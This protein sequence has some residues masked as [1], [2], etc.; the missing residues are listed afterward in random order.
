[1]KKL[2]PKFTF[3]SEWF[4][5][6][7]LIAVIIIAIWAYPQLPDIVPSHWNAAGEVDNYSS[8]LQHVLLFPGIMLGMYLLFLA[9]P[10]LEPRRGHFIKSW[11]FY[12][13]IKN[14]LMG[15]FLLMFGVTTWAG[16]GQSPI[17]IGTIVPLAVGVLLIMI[18]NYMPQIKSN[19]FMGIRT[20]WTLSSDKV[21]EKT[22]LLGGYTFAIGGL[23]F[24]GGVFLAAP[25]NFYIPM[26][27]VLVAALIPVVMSYI[28]F[29]QEKR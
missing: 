27:G 13:L 26:A 28:W 12:S 8:R 14:F 6:L 15:F 17:P 2:K 24:V 25:L 21:W 5:I 16:L 19:F 4:S 18:G 1:M 3:K 10:Y 9:L 11:G 22:H 29:L 20:P 7:A 23:L